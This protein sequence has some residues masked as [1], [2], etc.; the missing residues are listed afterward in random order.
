MITPEMPLDERLRHEALCGLHLLDTP[1]E[2][3]F[4]RIT[5]LAQAMFH[6]PI[7]L[8]SLVDRERQWFKSRQG[9]EATETPREISFCGHAILQEGVFLV[10]NALEDP[11]FHDNPLVTGGPAIRFYAG[12]P[13]HAPGGARVGTLCL[14]DTQPRAFSSDQCTQL[15]DLA[16]CVEAEF[17]RTGLM[18][19]FLERARAEA[20]IRSGEQRIRAIVDT[21]VDGIITIDAQGRIQTANPAAERIFGYSILEIRGQNVSLLMPAPYRE[22][23]DGYLHH[24]LVTGE[25]KVIGVGREVLGR[26]KDGS[27]FPMDLA[28]SEMEVEGERMFTGIVR[29]ISQRKEAEA[30]LHA[31]TT[32]R[33]AILD[34]ANVAI[35][36]TDSQGLILTWNRAAER[37]LGYSAAE[38]VQV[39]TPALIHDGEEVVRRAKELSLELGQ[40][41]EPGFEVFIARARL[42]EPE[43]R[44]WTYLRKDGSRLP[45]L[46]SV[47]AL[48]GVGEEV[49]GFLGI[50]LDLTER[51]RAET[52]KN[53]FISTVSHELRTPLT[54]IRG[55]LNL[56][57]GKVGASLP[58][59]VRT[60]LEMAE[61]NSE[62]LTL[63]INDILDLEKIEG[64]RL[65]FHFQSLDLVAV[66][67]R[68]LEENEGYARKHKVSLCMVD[69]PDRALVWGDEHRLLQVLANLVS[70][71][72]K[73]SPPEGQVELSI[74]QGQTGFTLEVRDHGPGIPLHFRD[75]IFQRF[76]QADG[77][78]ARE[79]GGT[80]LGLSITKAI[81]ERHE[82]RISYASELGVG[83]C[84]SVE[85]PA[86]VAIQ[87]ASGHAT[88]RA[89][90]CEDNLD[91]AKV[92]EAMLVSEQMVC[93]ISTSAGG[94]RELL[95][96]HT[97]RLMLLDLSLPD[98]DGLQF[99][100]ELRQDPATDKLPVIVVS[101]RAQEGQSLAGQG[102]M[103]LDWLQ[104]PVDRNR[105]SRS[106]QR[107]IHLGRH[108]RILHVEDDPDIVQIVLALLEGLA[109]VHHVAT[110][111]EAFERITTEEFDLVILDL[112]LAD[113]SGVDLLGPLKG[114]C[115]V[116]IFS[117]QV[118]GREIQDQVE[119]AL[120]KSMTTN[121]QLL[122]AVQKVLAQ[123]REHV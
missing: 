33:Q 31:L 55:A 79:K 48:R 8:V 24:Y 88:L 49:T 78:D 121:D 90:I 69:H 11:R 43:E 14:I 75:R 111:R 10:T 60:M 16:D 105:L 84:F 39:Q 6:V 35:I 59:K 116:V 63:L 107:A 99:L 57:M 110:K 62:R 109:E 113:G 47:T 80:G 51:K 29:D 2:P 30:R 64:G 117:A 101:G 70:N 22:A 94:A 28:V 42:G 118:P 92:L 72:I 114:R 26:R 37:M 66:V 85:L 50:A 120:T 74:H 67:R 65:E 100:Q 86:S 56:V 106:L 77:S 12:A 73:Y 102:L 81:V 119:V 4:D 87:E 95:A 46:L 20:Q 13:L 25:R 36:S 45:V 89:L 17:E 19:A 58:E 104:K 91:V 115:P 93:D 3:R 54:S 44:E 21:V 5:R 34:S 41:L 61:R 97:Y 108:H 82:G 7:V 38:M 15:R 32:L 96:R 40:T 122:G 71:A 23:H 76:A 103:V 98:I 9:L 123:P 52:L 27:T 53:E 83:T 112:G 68:G 1:A 18:E